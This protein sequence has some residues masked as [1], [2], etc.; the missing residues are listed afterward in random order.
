[1]IALTDNHLQRLQ[2]MA[3]SRIVPALGEELE[4][5]ARAIAEDAAESIRAGA[6]SGAGHVPSAPGEAPNK[7]TGDLDQSIHVGQV[8]ETP[9]SIRTS[10]IADSDHAWIERGGSKMEP[11]PYMEPAMERARSDVTEALGRR[12]TAEVIS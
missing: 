5:G 4:S 9:G 7:D 12:Y 6:I 2:R 3:P 11:R 8:I 10:V 1:M